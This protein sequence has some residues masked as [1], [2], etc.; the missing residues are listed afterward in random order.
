MKLFNS[1]TRKIEEFEPIK[2]PKVGLYTCGP[3]VYDFT[4][5]G[6]GRKYVN[7]DVLKRTLSYLGYEVKH[8]EN[9]TDVGHLVSDADAGE[10]KME[11]GAVKMGKTVWEVAQFY[12]DDFL[13]V[14]G[15]LGIIPPDVLCRATEHIPEQISMISKLIEKG[16]A[17][18]TE[19]AVYFEVGKFSGY[20]KLFGQKLAEKEVAVRSTVVA[21]EEKRNPADFALW[22]KRKGRFADHQMHWDSPWGDGFPGW[23]IECSAMST[24]YLGQQFDIHTGGEDHQ[25]IHHPNEIAQSEA[26]SGRHPFV[27]YWVHHAFLTVSGQKMSKSLG[28]FIRVSDVVDKGFDPLALRYLFLTTHYR[29]Q[30]NFT[31]ESLEAAAAA[32]KKLAGLVAS[33]GESAVGCAEFEER[34][35]NAVED[36]LNMP[37]ALAVVWEMAK[38]DYPGSAKKRSVLKFDEV[39]GLQLAAVSR[40]PTVEITNELK[41]LLAE[42]ERFRKDKKFKE[43]DRVRAEIEAR[44]YA[45]ED[46]SSG[47]RV[48]L[49]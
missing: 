11:K 44:G 42:R 13:K 14:M 30:M 21:G 48:K 5:I 46:T 34:F 18:E 7:D 40:Q 26:A 22:F 6:H 45:V 17:Y 20:D 33:W 39:L 16:F 15:Q 43:A 12:L 23:H 38:S 19:E 36:D 3:T 2:P 41:K 49:K 9:V 10:D 25:S 47:I 27:K 24:K 35:K 32:Y 8:V 28:N 1:L 4:H 37:E 31:W 29:K